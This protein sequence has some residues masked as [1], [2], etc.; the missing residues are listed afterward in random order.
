[1]RLGALHEADSHIGA[2]ARAVFFLPLKVEFRGLGKGPES[3]LRSWLV[4]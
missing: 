2:F 1:M 3:A 4:L